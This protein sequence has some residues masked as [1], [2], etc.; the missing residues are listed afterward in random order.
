MASEIHSRKLFE[1]NISSVNMTNITYD[2]VTEIEKYLGSR[3]MDLWTLA[4]LNCIYI[5]IFLTGIF[6][7]TCTCIVITRNRYMHTA[8]NYYLFSL[9]ISDVLILI[10]GKYSTVHHFISCWP[11]KCFTSLLNILRFL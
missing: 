8:T 7:N 10:L 3:Y 2:E 4:I 11:S 6:G 1:N 9:A 5:T